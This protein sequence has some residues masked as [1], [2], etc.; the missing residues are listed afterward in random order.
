MSN[1]HPVT[2]SGHRYSVVPPLV[3]FFHHVNIMTRILA[4]CP[5]CS[6]QNTKKW[7]LN[8]SWIKWG[9]R[10][11]PDGEHDQ[12]RQPKP[13]VFCSLVLLLPKEPPAFIGLG[14]RAASS[15]RTAR[16][17]SQG[18]AWN[19]WRTTIYRASYVWLG[20]DGTATTSATTV[21]CRLRSA[22]DE[23]WWARSMALCVVDHLKSWRGW[24]GRCSMGRWAHGPAAMFVWYWR[25]F[26][27]GEWWVKD[28]VECLL[29][30][31]VGL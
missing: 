7:N 22:L 29:C 8:L 17:V 1:L 4:W 23:E 16:L 9:L 13:P 31:H 14:R 6:W 15:R 2:E 11:G 12:I 19:R 3:F 24:S 26:G 10:M 30:G 21:P 28:F 20:L 27:D 18:V 25:G 5:G